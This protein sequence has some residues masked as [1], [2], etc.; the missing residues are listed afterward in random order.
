MNNKDINVVQ[1]FIAHC[2]RIETYLERC[3]NS[4]DEFQGDMLYQDGIAMQLLAM[5]E[6]TTHFSDEFKLAHS[7]NVD[8]R[9]LKQLRNIC[10]H[11]YE[12]I[13]F[14]ILWT[15]ATTEIPELKAY[16]TNLMQQAQESNYDL[17]L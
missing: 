14:E 16:F 17:E 3:N 4:Y 8:W 11:R 7:D 12:T 5:G 15:I 6:L 10:A 13:D 9:N 1:H 2:E